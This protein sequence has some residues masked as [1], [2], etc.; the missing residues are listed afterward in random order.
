MIMP[1][2]SAIIGA[3]TM[4]RQLGARL[5][6][7]VI[8]AKGGNR[9]PIRHRLGK[10]RGKRRIVALTVNNLAAENGQ[11]RT[12]MHDFIFGDGEIVIG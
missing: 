11:Y 7:L 3:T 12:Q 5:G 1:M 2:Y 8:A 6:R 9:G 10:L 4:Q